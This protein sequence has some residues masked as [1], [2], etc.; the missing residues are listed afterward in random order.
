MRTSSLKHL[1]YVSIFTIFIII[2]FLLVDKLKRSV[3]PAMG[4]FSRG[5]QTIVYTTDLPPTTSA[6]CYI[7]TTSSSQNFSRHIMLFISKLFSEVYRNI[8][9]LYLKESSQSARKLSLKTANG[10]A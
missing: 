10:K 6:F 1:L 9:I 4:S 2:L 7:R 3:V 5:H 8:Q